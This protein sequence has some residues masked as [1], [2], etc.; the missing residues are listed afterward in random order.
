MTTRTFEGAGATILFIDQGGSRKRLVFAMRNPD[1]VNNKKKLDE[2]EYPGGHVDDSDYDSTST[3]QEAVLFAAKREWD[4]EVFSYLPKDLRK[5]GNELFSYFMS[6]IR[7]KD[8]VDIIGGNPDKP[9]IRLFMPQIDLNL[10]INDGR[11]MLYHLIEF[12]D[13]EL[14]TSYQKD[15]SNVP[16]RG[17][18]SV[19]LE[20]VVDCVRRI[21]NDIA[22]L[23]ETLKGGKLMKAIGPHCAKHTVT[24]T[25]LS[26]GEQIQKAIR[27]FNFFTLR[28]LFQKVGVW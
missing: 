25:K 2:C 8:Y 5:R 13:R 17:V 9:Y 22:E 12:A 23:E 7:E 19:D 16:L 4:E 3:L 21:S 10:K 24:F 1:Y 18:V 20:D 28:A 27:K 11:D 14:E 26:N 6:N 15:K